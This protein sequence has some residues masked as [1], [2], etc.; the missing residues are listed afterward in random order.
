MKSET[1]VLS[2]AFLDRETDAGFLREYSKVLYHDLLAA[3]RE[4]EELRAAKEKSEQVE[5]D[6][7]TKYALLRRDYFG[8]GREKLS[9]QGIDRARDAG[10]Q[11]VLFH[12][13]SLVPAPEKKKIRRLEELRERHVMTESELDAELRL[14]EP[15][16]AEGFKAEWKEMAA[17][18]ADSKEITLIERR[19]VAILHERQKYKAS[20]TLASGEEKEV[21]I[22]APGPE[23]LLPGCTYGITMA[24]SV[25]CD[26]YLM[27][28]PLERQ[29]RQMEAQGLGGVPVKTLWNLCW[30]VGE[31]LRPMTEKIR[32][33]I[34]SENLC[35]HADETPWPVQGK[36]SDGYMWSMSNM[37]GSYYAFEPTRSGKVIEEMLAGFS[38]VLMSDGFSGYNRLK[39]QTEIKSANCWSH[40]RRKFFDIEDA[41]P[42]GP[43]RE[44]VEMLDELFSYERGV[45]TLEELREV[46]EGKSA[47]MVARIKL[48]MEEA[49]GQHLPES[50][51][52]K[53]IGYT[54]KL[55]PGLTLFLSDM[56]VPLSNNDAERTLRHAVVGRKNY[57]GSKTIDGAD[58]AATLFTVIESCKR[59]ELEPRAFIEMAVRRSARGEDLP[60]PLE[61]ARSIRAATT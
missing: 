55:W 40:V 37:A 12:A 2:T 46:R 45:K 49:I 43:A 61:Y 3:R 51:L 31:H 38:G 44:M 19:F 10:S 24:V 26:K 22:A 25:A 11:A 32:Q 52:R 5:L 53:A 9:S 47:P 54:L 23:K 18:T 58:L 1:K 27:H 20:I 17:F 30:A 41:T 16:L 6:L 8:S 50:P 48:W 57:Y 34:L 21:I 36:D 13:Q 33:E 28:L 60:S 35:V 4:L 15:G 39:L 59:V 7:N 29:R 42:G 14:R 56:R